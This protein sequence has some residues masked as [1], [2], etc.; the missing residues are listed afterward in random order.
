MPFVCPSSCPLLVAVGE[1]KQTHR[2][3]HSYTTDNRTMPTLSPQ[4]RCRFF[5]SSAAICAQ[6]VLHQRSSS[7]PSS[8]FLSLIPFYSPVPTSFPIP[9]SQFPT[10]VSSPFLLASP[11][12]LSFAFPHTRSCSSYAMPYS[13]ALQLPPWLLISNPGSLASRGLTKS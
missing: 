1:R 8:S 3:T 13:R 12:C 6:S 10:V 5:V 2:T 4:R 9:H 11:S 7:C